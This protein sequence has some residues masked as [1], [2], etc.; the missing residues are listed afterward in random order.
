MFIEKHRKKWL[1]AA[2]AIET[3]CATYGLKMAAH[4]AVVSIIYFAA[5]IGIAL[6]IISIPA[7]EKKQFVFVSTGKFN[8]YFK[9]AVFLI[10][11]VMAYIVANYWFYLIPIDIDYADMLPVIKVMNERFVAGQWKHVYDNIP[12]IWNGIR[13]VYLPAMWLPFSPAI[14]FNFDMRWITVCCL[15]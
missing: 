1:L 8:N 9:Y 14:M 5:G 11:V 7:P 2:F 15:L 10:M 4:T 3:L 6:L 12:E 13:P